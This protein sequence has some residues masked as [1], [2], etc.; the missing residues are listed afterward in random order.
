M[1]LVADT[2]KTIAISSGIAALISFVCPCL[3][4][5]AWAD[6]NQQFLKVF[7]NADRLCTARKFDQAVDILRQALRSSDNNP[8]VRERLARTLYMAG[9]SEEAIEELKLANQVDPNVFE[10]NA[11]L[12]WLYSMT[13]N[14]RDAVVYA[15]QAIRLDPD[16][17]YPYVILGFSLG[18]LGKK[19]QAGIALERAI[20]L[21]PENP[22]AHLYLADVLTSD[23]AYHDAIAQYREV[24]KREPRSAPAFVGVGSCFQRLGNQKDA[25]KAYTRAVELAPN[26]ATA[27][28]HLGFTLSQA[29]DFAGAFR[30][31]MVA[32]SIRINQSW[33][34]FIG[35]F[36]AVWAGI[37]IVFG[38]IFA[39][40]FVGSRFKPQLE[41]VVLGQYLLV[42]YR[43][44][45]GRLVVTDRR[46]VFVPELI[47]QSFGA[48]RV[49]IE[50]DQVS[51]IRSESK[52]SSGLLTIVSTSDTV[53][54]FRMPLLVF[55]PVVALLKEQALIK[56]IGDELLKSDASFKTGTTAE[57]EKKSAAKIG[58]FEQEQSDSQEE[59]LVTAASYDFRNQTDEAAGEQ[60]G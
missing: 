49:S 52:L 40:L 60:P 38:G 28:G 18:N 8:S 19:Q 29:G 32:N 26:D 47:S 58:P 21:E 46:I 43:D 30:N 17:A 54:T 59:E 5:R 4:D 13:E 53:H 35:V 24:L 34:K 11:D 50:R 27:R 12:A 56:E 55:S 42:F 22:L 51:S 57:N 20:E 37:F 44:R 33:N 39:A 36:V 9:R 14:Y 31:G 10:Y 45:P 23:G 16:R 48:T 6:D 15:N 1:R 41:E 7:E 3:T 2:T 25:L